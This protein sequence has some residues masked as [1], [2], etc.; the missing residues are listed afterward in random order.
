MNILTSK[1]V[2][3][4][5]CVWAIEIELVMANISSNKPWISSKIDDLS[6][7]QAIFN[8]TIS[9]KDVREFWEKQTL[10]QISN[11]LS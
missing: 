9:I 11:M 8:P 5:D 1:P 4:S 10:I 2:Y 6:M 7:P 3:G